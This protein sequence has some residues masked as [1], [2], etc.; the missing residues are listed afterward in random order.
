MIDLSRRLSAGETAL[1]VRGALVVFSALGILTQYLDMSSAEVLRAAHALIASWNRIPSAIVRALVDAVPWLPKVSPERAVF[2][3]NGLVLGGCVL[4]GGHAQRTIDPRWGGPWERVPALT[5]RVDTLA[6]VVFAPLGAI[7]ILNTNNLIPE[8]FHAA[9]AILPRI[10]IG[11]G[12]LYAAYHVLLSITVL[13]SFRK[14]VVFSL[15]II[16]IVEILYA[17]DLPR[18]SD[19]I[20][21]LSCTALKIAPEECR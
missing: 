17:L 10:G 18:I 19:D 6:T 14:G 3:G 5:T 15:S 11:L 20:N 7:A 9:I 8:R 2:I 13:K 1:A 4:L 12:I 16:A 21:R